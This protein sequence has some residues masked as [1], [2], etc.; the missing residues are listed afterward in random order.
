MIDSPASGAGYDDAASGTGEVDPVV[1]ALRGAGCVFAEEEAALL[2]EAAPTSGALQRLVAQRVDGEPLEYLLGWAEFRGL[3]VGVD[4]GVFVPRQRTAF[5]VDEAVAATAAGPGAHR[6]VVDLCC[7]SGAL[8]LAA[9][10][11]LRANGATVDLV[12]ADIDVAAVACARRNLEPV[13]GEVFHGDLCSALPDALLGHIDLLLA[14]TP[15]EPTAMIAHMPPEARDHEP[16]TAL[17]GGADGLDVLR[18]LAGQAARQ[19]APGGVLLVEISTAQRDSAAAIVAAAGL[20][21]SVAYSREYDA[22]VLHG[23]RR[24]VDAPTPRR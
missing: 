5:L 6:T 7:G 17:D 20:L 21:P 3:R 24:T 12:A 4:P 22:T 16:R 19:L 2:R 11:S 13:G 9:A 1:A 10:G 15:Y 23:A 14:N 18:R 8:G